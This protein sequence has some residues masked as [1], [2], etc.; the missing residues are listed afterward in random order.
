MELTLYFLICVIYC[1]IGLLLIDIAIIK[2]L[3][4]EK[5][6]V[7]KVGII[8]TYNYWFLMKYCSFLLNVLL[9]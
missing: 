6:G 9:S 8:Y 4:V 2:Y 7:F 1:E 5:T 3:A